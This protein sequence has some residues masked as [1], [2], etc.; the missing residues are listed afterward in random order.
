MKGIPVFFFFFNEEDDNAAQ[1]KKRKI[2]LN[3][4]LPFGVTSLSTYSWF[5]CTT[6]SSVV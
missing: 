5:M 4:D 1:S 6:A 2:L 3:L